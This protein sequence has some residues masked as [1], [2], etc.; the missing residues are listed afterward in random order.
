MNVIEED[1]D[2]NAV[3]V[4]KQNIDILKDENRKN[5]TEGYGY[6]YELLIIMLDLI[7]NMLKILIWIK[8]MNI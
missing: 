7:M 2:E 8:Y 5:N 3:E 6:L 1:F 4:Y